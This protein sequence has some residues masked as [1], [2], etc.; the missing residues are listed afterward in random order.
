MQVGR[1]TRAGLGMAIALAVA[2]PGPISGVVAADTPP[3]PAAGTTAEWT[4]R[5]VAPGVEVRTGTLRNA[6]AS[7]SWT[8]T[9][10]APVK[11]RFTGAR[12]WAAVGTESWASE[13]ADMLRTAGFEP[14]VRQI[15][16]PDYSDTPGGPMGVRVRIGSYATRNAAKSIASQ[17]TVAGF[18]PAVEWTGYDADQPADVRN[19]HVA[20]I[21]P[22]TFLG[23]ITATHEGDVTDRRPTSS[24]AATLGSLVGV[25]GGFFITSDDDGVQGTPAGIGAYDGEL[26]SMAVGSRAAL[27]LTD[28]GRRSR[29]TDLTTTVTARAGRSSYAVQGINRTPGLVRDCGRTGGKPTEEPR[30]DVTCTET[31]DLVRFTSEYVHALPTGPGVQVVLNSRDRAVSIGRRGGAVPPDHTVLQGIGSAADWLTARA[32]VGRKISVTEVIRD[33]D[34]RRVRLDADDSIVSAAPTLVEDGRTHIDA[35]AEGVVDPVDLSFGYTWAN[36]RQPRTMAGIDR[37]GRLLLVTVDGRLSGGSEGF[38]LTEGAAFM[39]SL[40]AVQAL[41]LDG[42][43]STAMAVN[44]TLVNRPSDPTGERPVGDTIQVLPRTP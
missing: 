27:I 36:K 25:N 1:I 16:W 44:G 35:A 19:I 37:R 15:P 39:R 22:R 14:A 20:V 23:S 29:I 8:V 10:R 21:D 3:I 34:G 17:V 13:T 31:D 24:V 5:T 12:A 2:V 26:T 30:Q 4:T 11:A 32:E 33:A 43:G 40:G 38:T 41:N 28:G 18:H 7:P 9:V 6:A 42:G